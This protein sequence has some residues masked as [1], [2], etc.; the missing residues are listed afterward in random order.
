MPTADDFRREVLEQIARAQ[1]QGRPHV[2]VNAGELHRLLG[3]YPGTSH[4]MPMCCGAMRERMSQADEIV[5]E[6]S[7]GAGASLTI[8][9][10]LP[11]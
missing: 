10:R 5:F 8:R 4:R 6:P 3:G 2:E 1:K 9:Y 7:A 11:R